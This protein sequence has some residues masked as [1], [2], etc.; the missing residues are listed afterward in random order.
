MNRFY[1]EKLVVSGGGHEASVLDF[2]PGLNFV[3]GPSQTG[4]TLVMECI[5]YAFGFIPKNDQPSKIVENSHGYERIALHLKTTGGTVVLERKIGSSKITVSGTDPAVSSGK[6]SVGH[7]A[8][9]NI[10]ALLLQLL[11]VDEPHS[12]RSSQKNNKTQ[13]LTWRSI[14]Y[15]FFLKQGD[16][17]RETSALYSPHVNARTSSAAA[18]LFLLT[19]QDANDLEKKEDPKIS[20]AKK[21]A[22]IVYIR[23]KTDQLAKR[24]EELERILGSMDA[25]DVNRGIEAIR[26]EIKNLQ[27]QIGETA[28]K[29]SKLMSDIYEWNSR[30]SECRTISHNFSA[31]RQQYQSDIRRISF[32]VDGAA[33]LSPRQSRKVKCPICGEETERIQDA[34]F[35]D[36][37]AS[38]LAKIRHH[39]EE[40]SDAQGTLSKR[41]ASIAH[42]ISQLEAQ[43]QAVDRLLEDELQPKL[44]AFQTRLE[45][46]LRLVRL[47]GELEAI[48]KDETQY[49]AE[50]FEKEN[51]EKPVEQTHNILSEYS[52]EVI[53]PFEEKLRSILIA[54]KFGGADKAR[55]NMENFDIEIDGLKKSVSMGG[56][57]CGILNT[58]MTIAMSEHLLEL[59]RIAPGFY[60]VDSSLTQLSE[61][62]HLSQ[63]NTIKQ[64]FIEYL[65]S[66][67]H[68]HQ[69]IIVEQTD[70]MPFMPHEDTETGIHV[71]EF[72]ANR[73]AGRYGF[74]NDVYNPEKRVSDGD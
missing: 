7:N 31:L 67:A 54:S 44:E 63:A 36:A 61:A 12:I 64:N 4:K 65:I 53:R 17:A 28:R 34:A 58:I 6:Y 15:L 60:A 5:D 23:D 59:D 18:L 16:V 35:I 25:E 38:E 66:R 56:G 47:S 69:V 22:L 2:C 27:S 55:L 74:L 70:R 49:R 71:V 1:I 33:A 20:E 39:L 29:S 68:V 73:N 14:M 45:N 13:D 41:E 46:Q 62:M 8:K 24:R 11:G 50:L 30:L 51:E 52:Y 57:Y 21:K 9:K 32:I 37:S 48:K 26:E 10:S 43:K 40:L 19:G 42:T 72:T 3:L